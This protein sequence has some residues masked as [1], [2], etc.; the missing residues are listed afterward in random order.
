MSF[1]RFLMR[2]LAVPLGGAVAICV[3]ALV[4]IAAHWN[5]FAT[6]ATIDASGEDVAVAL[7]VAGPWI[8]MVVAVSAT[9]MLLPAALG[10]LIAEVFAIRTWVY[11]AANGALSAWIGFNTMVQANE[12]Y[13][14]FGEPLIAVGAGI[15]G[16]FAYWLVAGWSAGFW[17][18]V[19]EPR[20]PQ[21]APPSALPPSPPPPAA[22]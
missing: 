19:F 10:A 16:G 18:P 9:A 12:P 5:R 21:A 7:F 22:A 3:A 20:P 15:A 6:L 1:G 17:K 2:F 11:H 4:V 8:A 13:D 14:F